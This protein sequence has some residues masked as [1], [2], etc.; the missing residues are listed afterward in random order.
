MRAPL[1]AAVALA[2]WCAA[3]A[4]AAAPELVRIG[5]FDEPVHVASP[6]NDPRVFV[7]ERAGLVKQ[8]GGGTFL[9][10]RQLTE[11]S[12]ERGLLS[13]A[14]PPDYVSTRRFFVFLTARYDGALQILEF[15]GRPSPRTVLWIPHPGAS[16]HN[17][18]QL[19][20]GSDGMLYAS[21][22]DGAVDPRTAQDPGN[23]LGKILRINPWSGAV[24]VWALGLRNPWRFSFDRATGDLLIG[25]VGAGAWEEIN[26]APNRAG[27]NFGW[28]CFE[29]NDVR[30]SCDPIDHT[31]P[32]LQRDRGGGPAAITGGYVVRDPGLP[33]LEGRYLYG[34][35]FQPALRSMTPAGGDDRAEPLA[36]AN[37]TSFGEDAC[38][39]LYVTSH[40]GPVYRI[41]DGAPSTCPLG[42]PPPT[43]PTP[44]TTDGPLLTDDFAPRVSVHT[45]GLATAARRRR[46]VLRVRCDE[47]CR[48]D[49]GGRLRGVGPLRTARRDL[50]AGARTALRVRFSRATARRLRATL[51]RRPRVVAAIAVRASDGAGNERAIDRR[52]RIRR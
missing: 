36:V 35:Y 28:P 30:L 12:G 50:A 3:P 1:A 23:L 13:I 19:Q 7:V 48:V 5:D 8:V 47:A 17:G 41:Q 27:F 32:V 43:G 14:F 16:N 26:A 33:T 40:A 46:I 4:A 20:F 9:D 6:P 11:T 49:A 52:A 18:G 44:P 38:G 45:R 39:R 15:R 22:G 21:T 29:G 51:R 2:L 25:D 37:P 10:V 31:R 34:D 42:P 24:Q